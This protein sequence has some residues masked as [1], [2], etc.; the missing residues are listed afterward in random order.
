MEAG[1]RFLARTLATLSTAFVVILALPAI[2]V[3]LALLT[4]LEWADD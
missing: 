1:L 2:L 3:F 4:I